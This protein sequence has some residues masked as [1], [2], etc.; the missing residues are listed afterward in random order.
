M[1]NY[2]SIC[3][4]GLCL[5]GSSCSS[6][7]DDSMIVGRVDNLENRVTTL[8]KLCKEAN[9]NISSLQSI[10]NVLKNNDYITKVTPLV[11]E[12]KTVGYTIEFTKSNPITIYHGEKGDKGDAGQNGQDGHTPQIGVKQDTDGLFYWTLEGDWLLDE[13]GTKIKAEGKDGTD[14]KPGVDGTDG[15]PGTNGTDGKPGV[16]GIDGKDGVTPQL[17]IEDGYW[18]VSYN[19]GS[20]WQKLGKA[21][22]ADGKP[23]VDGTDGKPGADGKPGTD[24]KP[25][26]DGDSMFQKIDTQSDSNYVIFTLA[27]GTE[28]KLPTWSAFEE[29]KTLC[30]QL[31]TN[32]A[33]IQT[34]VDALQQQDYIK[35]CTPLMDN[36]KQIGYTI[37]FAKQGAIVLYNG[38]DGA[39]GENA[40]T[41]IM[42]VK[43]GTDGFYYWTVDGRWLTDEQGNKI[44]AEGKDGADGKPGTDGKPG[45]D[46]KPGSDGKPG[47]DG[48]PGA[49]GIDGKD[50]V[51]PQL[52]IEDKYWYVSYNNGSTWQKLGKATGADGKPGVDGTDGKPG[53]DG[54][55]GTDGKPGVDGDS[56]FQKIDTQSDSNYV[57]FTLADGTEIKLPTWSAFEG[58]KTLCNQLNTSLSSLQKIVEGIQQQDYVTG[59]TPLMENGKQIG[60]TLTFAKQGSIVIYHGKDGLAGKDGNTPQIGVKKGSDDVYY[61]TIDGNFVKDTSGNKIK[62]EGVNGANGAD[63]K[64][65]TDGK[66]GVTPKLKIEDGFWYV[67]YDKGE[68][69][70]KLGKAI[71]NDGQSGAD[72]KPGLDGDSF[73]QNVT[74]D[75]KYVYLTLKDGTVVNVPKFNP[76]DITFSETKDIRLVPSKTYK[77]TYTI[78][79]ATPKTEVKVMAKD[80]YQANVRVTDNTKGVIEITTPSEI[81][82]GEVLVFVYNGDER[83]LMRSINFVE[84]VVLITD[85]SVVV[86]K[87]G[88]SIE[89]PIQTNINYSVE[90]PDAAKSWISLSSIRS[91]ASMRNETLT[92]SVRPNT[93]SNS[94]FVSVRLLDNSNITNETILIMQRGSLSQKTIHIATPGT[95]S[96]F[97]TAEN[98]DQI[99]ELSITGKLSWAD[100]LIFATMKN[101]KYLDLSRTDNI[102]MPACFEKT[103]I[104]TVLLP[105]KLTAIPDRAFYGANISSIV[106]PNSVQSIGKGAFANCRSMYLDPYN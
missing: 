51:T 33:G 78:T 63:G 2:F 12:Q 19:N 10:V 20:T 106:I 85:S 105:S 99:E 86:D 24:G 26:V 22:G 23:G 50:G 91:R 54:K 29:L 95:L 92:F 11:K 47:T 18:Y 56:M 9:T 75:E 64:P 97:I 74:Q 81:V 7:Y 87:N 40:H 104:Q 82:P 38:K 39:V 55:P 71:G 58:L 96:Q 57:I 73:F 21:T 84:G 46:G 36:G 30:N 102:T 49:D 59:C 43:K 17:K 32:L 76:F 65:G 79:G 6:D 48:K 98:K 101:L 52:K 45:I 93:T 42:G 60:Y 89:V 70:Q 34:I 13:H 83:T 67:S 90:I 80:G 62:A 16:D 31:N 41:P 77:I 37:T 8:E 25:G 5:L 66:D 61:W 14:G 3:M 68:S 44:K 1:K 27:D 53:A 15:T 94:R 103:T 28:I 69:W 35:D 4:L 72:G 100:F 88:G